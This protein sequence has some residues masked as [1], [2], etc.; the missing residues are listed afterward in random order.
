M[1]K[2]KFLHN[3]NYQLLGAAFISLNETQLIRIIVSELI[4]D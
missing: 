2:Y 1:S 4:D 3:F